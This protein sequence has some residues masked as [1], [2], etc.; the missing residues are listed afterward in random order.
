MDHDGDSNENVPKQKKSELLEGV[1][2]LKEQ[3]KL[4]IYLIFPD[5]YLSFS[6]SFLLSQRT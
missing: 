3:K 1:H 5:S 6:L 4:T 2:L